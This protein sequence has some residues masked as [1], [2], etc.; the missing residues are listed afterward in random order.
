M[1]VH[2]LAS[3]SEGGILDVDDIVSDVADDREK[4]GYDDLK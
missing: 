3:Q 4:V 2:S 1:H